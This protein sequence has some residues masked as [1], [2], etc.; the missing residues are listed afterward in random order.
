MNYEYIKNLIIIKKVN[1]LY[2]GLI[3][4]DNDVIRVLFN[5]LRALEYYNVNKRLNDLLEEKAQK[6]RDSF[7]KCK[8]PTVFGRRADDA[9]QLLIDLELDQNFKRSNSIK[10]T[11][12]RDAKINEI[13]NMLRNYNELFEVYCITFNNL[14]IPSNFKNY[15]YIDDVFINKLNYVE[16]TLD[17]ICNYEKLIKY[18]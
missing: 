5:K 16:K 11:Q 2:D 4:L 7:Y 18:N 10:F 9:C 14:R 17:I 15:K 8:R 3:V 6:I 12:E 1:D 13:I